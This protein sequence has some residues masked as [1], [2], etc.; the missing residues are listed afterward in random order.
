VPDDLPEEV[1]ETE[2]K[3]G[4][5]DAAAWRC[6]RLALAGHRLRAVV[7]QNHF[8]DRPDRRL[9]EARIGV[10]LRE[11]RP[12]DCA[13]R[14]DGA[15]FRLTVKAD[16]DA[17]EASDGRAK[18]AFL[19]RRVELEATLDGQRFAE[20]LD[21]GL[22]LGPWL[23]GW[24]REHPARSIVELLDDLAEH[25]GDA[26]LSRYGGFRNLREHFRVRLPDSEGDTGSGI[27]LELELD[28]CEF[29]G[30]RIDY[31]IEVERTSERR[32][33]QRT[34]RALAAWLATVCGTRPVS[35]ESKLARLEAA[36]AERPADSG[37]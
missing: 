5:V 7:Q 15:S 29:P 26:R 27:G 16:H 12:E 25:I 28:R 21:G 23:A 14:G 34:R 8:F 13:E 1:I 35:H 11:E 18:D 22:D 6:V 32:G 3:L 36:L 19:S 24:R 17:L 4:L 2:L 10:R 9:R 37:R 20:A 31:E 33:M 30:G